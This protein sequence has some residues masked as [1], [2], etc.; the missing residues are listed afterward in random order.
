MAYIGGVG[1]S[2]VDWLTRRAP[3]FVTTLELSD[4]VA[5]LTD[6]DRYAGVFALVTLHGEPLGTVTRAIAGGRCSGI[7]L[8]RAALDRLRWPIVRRLL[9]DHD[10][11]ANNESSSGRDRTPA[12]TGGPSSDVSVAVAV[13]TR[14][15]VSDLARCLDALTALDPPPDELVVVDNA[16]RTDETARIVA[17]HP[18]IRYVREDRPGLDWARS[19]AV[20]ETRSSVIA[21]TDDD[22]V[23]DRNWVGALRRAFDDSE[24]GAVTGLV[25]P[26]E[27]ETGAQLLFERYGGFGR[28]FERRWY[29]VDATKGERAA[30]MHAGPGKFGTGAN[31]AFRRSVLDAIGLF[32][33]A[34]DVGTVTNGGGDLE[35]FYRV[36]AAGRLLMYEPAAFVWHRHRRTYAAL[37]DQLTNHGIG[38]YSFLTCR[39]LRSRAD[40]VPFLRFAAFWLCRWPVR[41][42]LQALFKPG[43]FPRDLV[44]AELKGS[45][46]GVFR[47]P[48]AVRDA[49]RIASNH[50]GRPFQG[51]RHGP[52]QPPQGLRPS[53]VA[54]AKAERPSVRGSAM[55]STS[56]RAREALI[57]ALDRSMLSRNLDGKLRERFSATRPAIRRLDPAVGVS[58]VIATYD[59]PDQLRR[60]LGSI[61]AARTSRPVDIVVVDNN[62][63]SGLTPP[64][65]STFTGVR[66]IAEGRRG[67]AYARNA[68]I[69]ASRGA[70]I[71]TTDD[72]VEVPEQWLEALVAPFE[73]PDVMIVTGN[74]LAAGGL[75][76]AQ[77]TFEAYGGLGRG[78]TRLDVDGEWFWA[79]RKSVPTWTLGAT[80]NA[81]FRAGIFSDPRIGV[82]DEALGAG[83]PAGC[84]EDTDLF[85]R[86]LRAGYRLI[87]E[88]RAFVW[89]HHRSD[90]HALGRQIYAYAK[91]HVAY[92]LTTL[93]RDRDWRALI[94]LF[95]EL[96]F[97]PAW[98]LQTRRSAP[99]GYPLSLVLIEIFGTL[100]GPLA[101]W[102]SRR[103]ARRLGRTAPYLPALN[104]STHDIQAESPRVQE[105]AAQRSLEALA[106][107]AGKT[108]GQL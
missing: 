46:R 16:P 98:R 4:A 97:V 39:I 104:R 47:Y 53:A 25:L 96:P 77:Q 44:M 7:S 94:R 3:L 49:R 50:A 40:R 30:V 33:P 32:D 19:R 59:R 1:T 76:Q 41:R 63:Q 92:Q 17:R 103:R 23:V 61:A 42:L 54:V 11:D 108:G 82:F 95:G 24:V 27:L 81:A 43:V 62:P 99:N 22:V 86:V 5:D 89:H 28:G 73:G 100:A 58:I 35:M 88:P 60:A 37:R 48:A 2:A 79:F 70:I 56:S 64:V 29:Q 87:Y 8:R 36:V 10:I 20:L 52:D 72:D 38:L 84:S 31:M 107:V 74:V 102:Q 105:R 18:H 51:G 69:A 93:T 65:V 85:Y 55:P 91:G 83:T 71:I 106:G 68:G 26:L 101:W 78:F 66:L 13:C 15:R 9:I 6:M 21:F 14:D 75:S 80:A 12:A 90:M 57:D 45:L 34:L 67:L